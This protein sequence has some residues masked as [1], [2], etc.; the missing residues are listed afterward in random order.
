LSAR[1]QRVACLLELGLQRGIGARTLVSQRARVENPDGR[2][3]GN[4]RHEEQAE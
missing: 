2:D 1:P 4:A 3:D